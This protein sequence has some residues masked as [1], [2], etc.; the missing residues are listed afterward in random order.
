MTVPL[1][2]CTIVGDSCVVKAAGGMVRHRVD[3]SSIASL[4][5]D[6]ELKTLELEYVS[7]GVY[8]YFDVPPSVHAQL[9]AAESKGRFVNTVIKKHYRF[10]RLS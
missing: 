2:C 4:G 6:S 5:Y 7:G 10:I 1:G 9:M 3:S 8:R